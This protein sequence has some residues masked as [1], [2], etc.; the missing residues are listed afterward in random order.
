MFG[1]SSVLLYSWSKYRIVLRGVR[2][3]RG[4]KLRIQHRQRVRLATIAYDLQ[5]FECL[6]NLSICALLFGL[7]YVRRLI[8]VTAI[9]EKVGKR[10]FK[11]ASCSASVL[12]LLYSWNFAHVLLIRNARVFSFL[13]WLLFSTF[14]IHKLSMCSSVLF[15]REILTVLFFLFAL[16]NEADASTIIYHHLHSYEERI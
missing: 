1:K 11:F 15:S 16:S 10:H 7:Y 5:N 13:T 3:T 12:C 8:V 9:S 14:A 4:F 2:W 6:L